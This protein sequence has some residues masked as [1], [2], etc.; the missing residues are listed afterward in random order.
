MA[1]ARTGRLIEAT[2]KQGVRYREARFLPEGKSLLAVDRIC[3]AGEGDTVLLLKEGTGIRQLF[4]MAKT[5]K[6][7]IDTCVA[8]IVDSVDVGSLERA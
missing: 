5:D 3:S 2:R 8:A 1:S 7:P 4:G 6:L